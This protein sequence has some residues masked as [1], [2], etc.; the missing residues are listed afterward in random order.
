MGAVPGVCVRIRVA[1]LFTPH[2]NKRPLVIGDPPGTRFSAARDFVFLHRLL[3]SQIMADVLPKKNE[4]YGTK[5]Y[6]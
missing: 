3:G 1:R 5:Q 4:E 6:W 2:S